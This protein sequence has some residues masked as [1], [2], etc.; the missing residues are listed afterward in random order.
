MHYSRLTPGQ[1]VLL[2][3]RGSRSKYH[4]QFIHRTPAEHSKSGQAVNAFIVDEFAGLTGPDD[5]G[6]VYLSDLAVSQRVKP[7]EVH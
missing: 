3:V 4:G 7:A 6:D 1:R 2:T 5:V